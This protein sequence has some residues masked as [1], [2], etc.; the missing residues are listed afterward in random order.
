MNKLIVLPTFL[1]VKW[2]TIISILYPKTLGT[3]PYILVGNR[4]Y[5]VCRWG[6]YSCLPPRIACQCL[7]HSQITNCYQNRYRISQT[8][9]SINHLYAGKNFLKIKK[10][11]VYIKGLLGW[12]A[13]TLPLPLCSLTKMYGIPAKVAAKSLGIITNLSRRTVPYRFRKNIWLDY[14]ILLVF[15]DQI[16]HWSG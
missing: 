16:S 15:S 10:L 3:M 13:W 11:T 8:P 9:N 4:G 7:R 5:T 12:W 2:S 6:W 1:V 14:W